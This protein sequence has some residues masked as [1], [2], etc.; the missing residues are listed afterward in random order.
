MKELIFSIADIFNSDTQSGCLSQYD[1]KFYHIPPYQRGYKWSSDKN[2]G[3]TVLI[4][5]LWSAFN[6]S[7]ESDRK[8]Y[9]LQYITVKPIQTDKGKCLEVI[10]GQQRLTTLSIMLSVISSEL[11]HENIATGK[12]DYAI[13]GNFFTE[14]IYRTEG[15]KTIVQL[16]WDYFKSENTDL[17]KQDIFYMHAAARKCSE[18][19][20]STQYKKE[21]EAFYQFLLINVKL[22]VNSVESH[23]D[24]ET[25]FRNLNSNKV[26]L[27]E[28][29]LI[30]GLLI[31]KVGRQTQKNHTKNFQEIIEVRSNIGR[32]WDELSSWANRPDISSFYFNNHSDAMG[33]LLKLTAK[34]L[35][36]KDHKLEKGASASDLTIFNFYLNREGFIESF[37][38]LVEIKNKLDNLFDKTIIY[39]LLGFARYHKSS[40]HNNLTFLVGLLKNESKRRIEDDLKSKRENLLKGIKPSEL[41]YSEN[42]DEIHQVLLALNVFIEGQ[43][44]IRFDFYNYE[45][46]KWSLE[47]IFPQTPEGLK[48]VL[49]EEGKNA[50]ID[51]LGETITQEVRDVLAKETRTDPEKEIYYKALN[52]HPALNSLGNM[53]LLT[54]GDNASNGNKFFNEKRENILK[55]IRKGSFVPRHTFDVFSKMFPNAAIEDMKVWTVVDIDANLKHIVD[56]LK[57]ETK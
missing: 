20:G 28:A 35:E 10:D 14:H 25:V 48:K 31:T 45:K 41:S 30:K 22:I 13:R 55:L 11:E 57:L 32:R 3:V 29:E 53:C 8:E 4:N 6:K 7:K 50:I 44:S 24:S 12:L 36:D 39:N 51:L 2:G 26:P 54:G 1:A 33:Q 18:T 43:Q 56:S 38:A 46:Q 5:D 19:F 27:T 23:I 42:N 52:E 47:H 49:T 16:S 17:N 37:Q 40:A 21:L 9:Y 34:Y 15:L